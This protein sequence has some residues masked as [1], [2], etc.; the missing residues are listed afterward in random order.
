MTLFDILVLPE[1]RQDLLD[2]MKDR[3]WAVTFPT[4]SYV[5]SREGDGWL[6]L[7]TLSGIPTY[8]YQSSGDGE[9]ITL[10]DGKVRS[11]DLAPDG[12]LT[13]SNCADFS[14]ITI[15]STSWMVI[16]QVCWTKEGIR[17]RMGVEADTLT[18]KQKRKLCPSYPI[19]AHFLVGNRDL[20]PDMPLWQRL[21]EVAMDLDVELPVVVKANGEVVNYHD[22]PDIADEDIILTDEMAFGPD[23]LIYLG[24]RHAGVATPGTVMNVRLRFF[25]NADNHLIFKY[26]IPTLEINTG[27]S[28]PIPSACRVVVENPSGPDTVEY[29]IDEVD[30]TADYLG[31]FGDRTDLSEEERMILAL[32]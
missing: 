13:A 25:M 29:Y 26:E 2:L 8:Q 32:M 23:R 11:V 3:D 18:V 31:Q 24:W 1:H 19:D 7:V 16:D 21:P 10:L 5:G 28:F 6:I 4:R 17:E 20:L 22:C 14:T 27:I 30:R 9:S 15:N 12:T